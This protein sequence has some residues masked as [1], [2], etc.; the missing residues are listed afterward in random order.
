[1]NE[2]FLEPESEFKAGN[3]KKYEIEIIK[4]NIVYAKKAER[5]LQG[6]YYLFSWKS[7]LEKKSTWEPSSTIMQFWKMIFIFYK[8]HPK[9]PRAISLPFDFTLSMAKPLVKQVRPSAKQKRSIYQ[10]QQNASKNKILDDK[11]FFS[12]PN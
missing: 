10:T 2:L 6:L 11:V 8:N 9:K 12:C 4:D 7:N 1:M 3:N 5:H